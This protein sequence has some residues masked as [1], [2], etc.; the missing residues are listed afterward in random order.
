[1]NFQNII[2][3]DKYIINQELQDNWPHKSRIVVKGQPG[4]Y[5]VMFRILNNDSKT[6]VSNYI[7]YNSL[8]CSILYTFNSIQ[9]R[10]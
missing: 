9:C 3:P 6:L 4:I 7:Y 10:V 2:N 8:L 5:L 1:M